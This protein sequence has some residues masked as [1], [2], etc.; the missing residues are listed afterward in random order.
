MYESNQLTQIAIGLA[1]NRFISALKQ[2]A[3]LFVF[4]V[5]VLAV[6]RQHTLHD[7]AYSVVLP[8]DQQVSVV[9]HQAVCV[10]KERPLSLLFCEHMQESEVVVVRA[11]DLSSIIPSGDYMIETSGDLDP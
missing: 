2:V 4:S 7:S 9:W 11:E 10:K 1:E 8:F 6:A 5:E 3:D